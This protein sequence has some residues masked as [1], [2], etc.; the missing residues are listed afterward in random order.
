[1]TA[2][3]G[4]SS[5]N[6]L[7]VIVCDY[8]TP[9][10]LDEFLASYAKYPPRMFGGLWVVL[11]QPTER[12]QVV[13]DKWLPI[14][15]FEVIEFE[16]NVGYAKACNIA[17]AQGESD[18]IALFNADVVLTPSALRQCAYALWD[19]DNW[20]IL[21]PRQV[22][23][24]NRITAGGVFGPPD[25]PAQRSWLEPD[26][27]QCSDIRTDALTVSGAAFFV[28]RSVWNE[29]TDCPIYQEVTGGAEGAFLST[30][31]HYY[32]ETAASYHARFHGLQV[33]FYGPVCITHKWHQA[34][35]PGSW[36]DQQMGVARTRFREFC[37]AHGIPC[38]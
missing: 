31:H 2:S 18:V 30:V 1:M 22:D 33:V 23:V 28:K 6:S 29:L 34:S 37:G 24:M 38:E 19:D 9:G 17:A 10:D 32:E 13:V 12:D 35:A 16:E 25:R 20:A 36:V 5:V 11:V 4:G 21:G 27:G 3:Q 14:L 26:K 8:Q 7:D 15:A